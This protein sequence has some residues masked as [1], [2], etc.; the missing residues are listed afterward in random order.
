MAARISGIDAL[1]ILDSRGNPTVRV[2]VTLNNGITAS[3]SVPSGASTGEKEAL[4]LRDGDP[5]RYRKKGVKKAV[6]NVRERIAPK[7]I[8]LNPAQ[9]AEIDQILIA[10]D[11]TPN[12]EKLGAN[13]TLGVSMAVARAAAMSADLPLYAYLGGPGAVRLPMP[14]MNI[15]NGG[16]HAGNNVDFQE[17]M[18]VPV[19]A[20][21]FSEGLRWSAEIFHT[22]KEILGKKGHS[23]SVGDEGGFAPNLQSNDLACELILKAIGEKRGGLGPGPGSQFL[24]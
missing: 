15:V 13:A 19:G 20:P 23:T 9:Q 3:A 17:F 5:K 11:G 21:T 1:E 18:I 8:G 10:L 12:K 4:E 22:L 24:L 14:M 6:A 2:Y 16:K 7:L